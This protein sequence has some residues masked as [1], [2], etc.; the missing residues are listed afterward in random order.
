MPSRRDPV[1]VPAARRQETSLAQTA[2]RPWRLP[3]APWVMG[4]TWRDLLFAHWRVEPA[5]LAPFVPPG[6]RLETWDGSAWL[7]VTPFVV[8]ALRPRMAPR[9]YAGA[10]FL[11]T[12][13]RTYVTR[14]DRAGI[15]FLSLD[16]S[17]RL[18]VAAARTLYRLPYHHA[19]MDRAAGE[20]TDY[21]SSRQGLT[22][23]ARYAPHGEGW[24]ADPGT[25]EAFLV[26]R[27][28]LY[29]SS[30]GVLLRA[31]I[32]H[33]PWTLHAA[34]PGT[35]IDVALGFARLTLRGDP[36]LHVAPVQDVAV[37]APVPVGFRAAVEP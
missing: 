35:S 30:A 12:N 23:H 3:R 9:W 2:H 14:D 25:L 37:W 16:A 1:S 22:V 31:D 5:E 33:R 26:E 8:C 18:A 11:E 19:H 21:R 7:G 34:A 20:F 29:S 10:R 4:Q 15:V 27:Y 32:H 6:L 24:H 36:L 13:V 28:C 17:S